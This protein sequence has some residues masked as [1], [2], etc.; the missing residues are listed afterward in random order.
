MKVQPETIYT[1]Q[2]RQIQGQ[3]QVI[4]T[5]LVDT[6][7]L[8]NTRKALTK[9]SEHCHRILKNLAKLPLEF[10]F[11]KYESYFS[12]ILDNMGKTLL[13][14]VLP[15]IKFDDSQDFNF[16]Y[17][18]GYDSIL[19]SVEQ[20]RFTLE[21][22]GISCGVGYQV[23]SSK[24]KPIKYKISDTNY[25]YHCLLSAYPEDKLKTGRPFTPGGTHA[26]ISGDI[27]LE[28]GELF[29]VLNIRIPDSS[30]ES[31]P[32]HMMDSG[33]ARFLG[34]VSLDLDTEDCESWGRQVAETLNSE[35]V[36]SK[37][38][39]PVP[40]HPCKPLLKK[41]K[42]VQKNTYEIQDIREKLY[43]LW[44]MANFDPTWVNEWKDDS[45]HWVHKFL[46]VLDKKGL[47][48]LSNRIRQTA[49]SEKLAGSHT[50]RNWYTVRLDK[51]IALEQNAGYLEDLGSAMFLTSHPIPPIY[52]R[53]IKTW[54]EQIY[55]QMRYFEGATIQEKLGL[56]VGKL[57]QASAFAHQARGLV[58]SIWD[59][60]Q[61]PNLSSRSTGALWH[62]RTLVKVWGNVKLRPLDSIFEGN[63]ALSHW[64]G[65]SNQ[66]LLDRIIDLGLHQALQ[67]A[68][69]DRDPKDIVGVKLQQ[70][71]NRL[72]DVKI[73]E[74]RKELGIE[75]YGKPQDWVISRGFVWCFHHCFW[76]SAYHAFR[77]L[78]N[79]QKRPYLK[80]V[81]DNN[82]I[83]IINRAESST[84]KRHNGAIKDRSFFDR[85][86]DR[87]EHCFEIKGPFQD[88]DEW[89]TVIIKKTS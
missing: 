60:E 55:L 84:A 16:Y 5:R 45:N 26:W 14:A 86:E 24:L 69:K 18:P 72:W 2:T 65:L 49:S 51:T 3:E 82:E 77:A 23:K 87:I 40:L 22:K 48:E 31:Y 63:E 89:Q 4:A 10:R 19:R 73:S 43:S 68:D 78:A 37:L 36:K 46:A 52:F 11:D 13:D 20:K 44:L 39:W 74:T 47:S 25:W 67:R 7:Q 83:A 58:D 6:E 62:L 42:H 29:D 32:D 79:D 15:H 64:K 85:L 1:M 59:D 41:S 33:L 9:G 61:I 75:T 8:I 88:G 70:L 71:L 12:K 35:N 80:I 56:S 53:M 34:M 54:I 76:Q 66:E 28:D 21:D 81:F 57:S 17:W 30:N 38:I 27:K 50:F